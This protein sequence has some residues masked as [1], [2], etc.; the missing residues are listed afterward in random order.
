MNYDNRRIDVAP[1]IS[2]E[3][4][5]WAGGDGATPVLCLHGL[6]RN[7]A[8]FDDVAQ[9]LARTGR[10]VAALSLRGRGASDYDPDIKNYFP[11]TYRDDAIKALDDL[12]WRRAVFIGTSLGGITTMLVHEAAPERVA[13]AIINDVGPELAEEGLARIGSYAGKTEGPARDIAEAAARI[14]AI[15]AVAFPDETGDEYWIDFARRTFRETPDGW[16]L[17]Y[18]PAIGAALAANGPAPDL[19]P[20]W[21][22]LAET[23]TLMVHGELSDLMTDP[24]IE[25]MRAAHPNFDYVR[26]PRVGHAPML[27]EP[28]AA[29]AIEDFLK[30]LDRSGA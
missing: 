22:A 14:R 1:G 4:R 23:P 6:T 29:T 20:A 17:D 12:G 8:D 28:A 11:T 30:E 7:A 25:K 26:V 24:I 15:N 10:D 16:V 18:D 27:T 19:W 5:V 2:L 13:A 21:S 3:A 9:A